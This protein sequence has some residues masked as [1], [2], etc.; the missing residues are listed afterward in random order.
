MSL[1]TVSL[2]PE[3]V[4]SSYVSSDVNFK[5][6]EMLSPAPWFRLLSEKPKVLL[7]K[8]APK[9]SMMVDLPPLLGPTRIVRPLP[10]LPVG[11]ANRSFSGL[12]KPLRPLIVNDFTGISSFEAVTIY[13]ELHSCGHI[14]TPFPFWHMEF[15]LPSFSGGLSLGPQKQRA[16]R[17]RKLRFHVSVTRSMREIRGFA[18]MYLKVWPAAGDT[19]RAAPPAR[20]VAG[21]VMLVF[22]GYCAGAG[23]YRADF[24]LSGARDLLQVAGRARR[25]ALTHSGS[26][27]RRGRDRG[28][29][30]AAGHCPGAAPRPA[31][32]RAPGRKASP[33]VASRWKQKSAGRST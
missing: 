24:G 20:Q 16:Q 25:A 31:I 32:G 27:C 18:A 28:N 23:R 12:E 30:A 6:N 15:P 2:L 22:S 7:L 17:L 9:A 13:L 11:F 4:R 3:T 5:S 33:R 26:A 29:G 8:T 21:V 14:R 1:D 19:F 10:T